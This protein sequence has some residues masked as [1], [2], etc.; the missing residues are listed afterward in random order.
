MLLAS[1]MVPNHSGMDASW[2]FSHPERYIYTASNPDPNF[3]FN[4]PNLS[5]NPDGEIYIEK[6]YY[7]QTGAAEVF[8]FVSHIDGET[9]FVYH[10]NDGTSMP[11]N[12]TAQLNYLIP[13]TRPRGA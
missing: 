1:D 3:H 2:M 9:R 5:N 11:W 6:G 10:G 12:D 4:T 13:E 7:D 8:K